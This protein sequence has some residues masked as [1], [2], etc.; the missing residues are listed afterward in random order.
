MDYFANDYESRYFRLREA[1]WGIKNARCM[2][3]GYERKLP[4]ARKKQ[5]KGFEFFRPRHAVRS[6]RHSGVVPKSV[7]RHWLERNAT[8]LGYEEIPF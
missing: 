2:P 3:L 4:S 5:R 7:A 8:R 6:I 1:L